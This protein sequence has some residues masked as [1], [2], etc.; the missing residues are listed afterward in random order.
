VKHT[1]LLLL[2][3]TSLTGC[4][5]TETSA[6]TIEKEILSEKFLTDTWLGTTIFKDSAYLAIP[7][8]LKSVDSISGAYIGMIVPY[9]REL[10]PNG[11]DTLSL[12]WMIDGYW[13]GTWELKND[14]LI[15]TDDDDIIGTVKY[16]VRII[17]HDKIEL[18][19]SYIDS[20]TD[21]QEVEYT[22]MERHR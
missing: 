13:S 11:K 7:D 9:Y 19:R 4:T 1:L 5:Q 12:T 15:F 17:S 21:R 18:T 16:A 6:T 14:S 8:S 22:F 3:V 20:E 10:D 2:L